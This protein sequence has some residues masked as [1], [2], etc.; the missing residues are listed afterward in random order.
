M[1][2]YIWYR[3][4]VGIRIPRCPTH[5]LPLEV[6]RRKIGTEHV[7][8]LQSSPGILSPSS[9]NR[10]PANVAPSSIANPMDVTNTAGRIELT[11]GV[12]AAYDPHMLGFS[13]VLSRILRAL[14]TEITDCPTFAPLLPKVDLE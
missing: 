7:A 12:G 1:G 13:D 9:N 3:P 8:Q 2:D 4:S 10:S 11:P 14:S 6:A 5:Q